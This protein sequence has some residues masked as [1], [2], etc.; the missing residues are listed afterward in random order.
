MKRYLSLGL[1]AAFAFGGAAQ[2]GLL[3]FGDDDAAEAESCGPRAPEPQDPCYG[4]A[5]NETDVLVKLKPCAYRDK[6]YN[7]Y[8]Y[9][10]IAEKEVSSGSYD[11]QASPIK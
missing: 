1:L 9:K 4:C 11:W 10:K 5:P 8:T 3:G 2:A 7:Y 6:P